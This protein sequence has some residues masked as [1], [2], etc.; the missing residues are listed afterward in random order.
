MRGKGTK[1]LSGSQVI[2]YNCSALPWHC[3]VVALAWAFFS[4]P[5]VLF[6][7][8][9]FSPPVCCWNGSLEAF[10][11][12]LF[13]KVKLKPL[14]WPRAQWQPSHRYGKKWGPNRGHLCDHRERGGHKGPSIHCQDDPARVAGGVAGGGRSTQQGLCE[15]EIHR[16]PDRRQLSA[17]GCLAAGAGLCSGQAGWSSCVFSL[18]GVRLGGPSLSSSNLACEKLWMPQWLRGGWASWTAS[19]Y[20]HNNWSDF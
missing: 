5:S 19:G 14:W 3:S 11:W 13:G 20:S 1:R 16:D 9:F 18:A 2:W 15:L 17:S 4:F 8:F 10:A 6:F 7:S 12:G